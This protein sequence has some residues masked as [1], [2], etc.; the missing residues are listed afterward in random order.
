MSTDTT[1]NG[2]RNV[3]TWRVQLHLAND[4][5]YRGEVSTA[6]RRYISD[7]PADASGPWGDLVLPWEDR[8]SF[9][10]LLREFVTFHAVED[11]VEDTWGQFR[12][13]VVSAALAR[14]DWEQIAAHWLESARHEVEQEGRA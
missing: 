3:E 6:A 5:T 11:P 7:H 4:E 2:W 10:E 1:Y 14:V 8:K 13:D 12:G 9:A